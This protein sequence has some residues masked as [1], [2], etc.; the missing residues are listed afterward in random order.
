[1]IG[2]FFNFPNAQGVGQTQIFRPTTTT[3][4]FHKWVKP[5]GSSLHIFYVLAGG[6]GGGSGFTRAAGA[7]G[8][9]GGGGGTSSFARIFIPSI[10]IPDMLFIAPGVGGAT[11]AGGTN[12]IVA[13]QPSTNTAFGFLFANAG[14]AGGNGS[15]AAG[16]GGGAAGGT[17]LG[18]SI[19]YLGVPVIIG[20]N[21]GVAGG[22]QTGAVGSSKVIDQTSFICSAGAGGAGC[23]TTDFAGGNITGIAG[24][25]P[26]LPGGTAGTGIPGTNGIA[27]PNIFGGWGGAGGGSN[28]AATAGKGGDGWF[29][30]GGGGGG[31]GT[32]GGAG[33]RGGMGV[34]VIVSI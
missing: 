3:A 27:L 10:A 14:G 24:F 6:G 29:G 7:A 31:A 32:T 16:G 30:C 33:G 18:A 34:V 17:T 2:D 19:A 28:D 11:G 23:T 1:M 25:Y 22:A 13:I 9:G 15:G 5:K 8:G 20:G 12:S 4:F 26:D 21:G